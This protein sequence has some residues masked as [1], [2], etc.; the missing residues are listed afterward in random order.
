MDL[1]AI[2]KLLGISTVCPR[3]GNDLIDTNKPVTPVTPVTEVFPHKIVFERESDEGNG[4]G[5]VVYFP[6]LSDREVSSVALNGEVAV[7]GNAYQGHPVFKLSKTG[8]QYTR[9]LKFSIVC[10]G[11]IYVAEQSSSAEPTTP[12]G[13]NSATSKPD[14]YANEGRGNARFPYVGAHY[15]KNIEVWIDG[16]LKMRVADGSKRQEGKNGLTW[17]PISENTGK[18]VV[19]GEFNTQFN[20]CTIKW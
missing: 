4:D 14:G 6:S 9:P 7:K 16:V 15:G 20:S 19:I 8:D 3:C 17:K 12:S 2:A 11:V 13:G 5:A 1:K 10:G 18:L